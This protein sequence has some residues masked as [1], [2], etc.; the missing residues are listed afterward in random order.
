MQSTDKTHSGTSAKR[1]VL[2][3]EPM[4]LT[5]VGAFGDVLKGNTGTRGDGGTKRAD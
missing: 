5:R 1:P 3:W 4:S 2:R